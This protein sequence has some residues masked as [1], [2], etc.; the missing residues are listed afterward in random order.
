MLTSLFCYMEGPLARDGHNVIGLVFLFYFYMD[1]YRVLVVSRVLHDVRVLSRRLRFVPDRPF[2]EMQNKTEN[3]VSNDDLQYIFSHHTG[4]DKNGMFEHR[5]G[6]EK[7]SFLFCFL[8]FTFLVL[9]LLG[10]LLIFPD[11]FIADA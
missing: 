11:L 3:N 5:G 8:F 2:T 1:F 4:S 10:F 6:P 7:L 9:F